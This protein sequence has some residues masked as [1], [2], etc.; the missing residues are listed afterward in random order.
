M[1]EM[2]LTCGSDGQ[3]LLDSSQLGGL[4]GCWVGGV[5]SISRAILQETDDILTH[6]ITSA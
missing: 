4:D 1:M 2:G 6:H 3:G 5:S